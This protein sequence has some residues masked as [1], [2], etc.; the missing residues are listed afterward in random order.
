MDRTARQG[1]RAGHADARSR[2]HLAG[3]AS[4]RD[5]FLS[6]GRSSQR[7]QDPQHEGVRHV[8]GDHGG[9]DATG[10]A[11][12]R[13]RRRNPAR[14]RVFRERDR[15]TG[16]RR[17]DQGGARRARRIETHGFRAHSQPGIDPRRGGKNL[18]ALRRCLLAEEG[19]GR[20]LSRRL[21]QGAGGRRLARHLHSRRIWR[22]WPGHR[23]CRDHD[24]DDLGIRRRH[25]RR[26]RRAYERVRAQSRR[27]VRHQGAVQADAAADRRRQ[28]RRPA[29]PSPSRIPVSTPRS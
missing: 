29:L 19:Q 25:V 3:P 7:R 4:G 23:R 28:P 5:R 26:L 6:G 16:A 14:G 10:A 12:E 17:R 2:E 13:T 11:P 8:V 27:R 15:S 9:A 24:A 21:P 20:R 22:L 1:R 18:R